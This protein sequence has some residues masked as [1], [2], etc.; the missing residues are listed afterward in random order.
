MH[1]QHSTPHN[2]NKTLV[3]QIDFRNVIHKGRESI[4]PKDDVM[5]CI[6]RQQHDTEPRT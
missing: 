1:F 2:R 5:L 3:L 4:P 6:L